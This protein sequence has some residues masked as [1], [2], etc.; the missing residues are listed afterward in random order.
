MRYLVS[1]TW[2]RRWKKKFWWEVFHKHYELTATDS[3]RD[4]Y[5]VAREYARD[6][7]NFR[8]DFKVSGK[9]AQAEVLDKKTN[10]V[11]LIVACLSVDPTLM[12]MTV[13]RPHKA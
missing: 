9:Y 1:A 10:Q 4:A 7:G 13:V 2:T 12:E 11:V 8:G 3:L 6:L 5:E